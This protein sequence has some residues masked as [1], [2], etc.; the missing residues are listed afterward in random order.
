MIP[1]QQDN[2]G[3]LYGSINSHSIGRKRDLMYRSS[4]LLT[5]L[6]FF[7]TKVSRWIC[8]PLLKRTLCDG[9]DFESLRYPRYC[10]YCLPANTV[11]RKENILKFRI[12]SSPKQCT[13]EVTEWVKKHSLNKLKID[14]SM[15]GQNPWLL[16]ALYIWK[17]YS[18]WFSLSICLTTNS[19]Q[20]QPNQNLAECND[21]H[22]NDF[23]LNVFWISSSPQ[24]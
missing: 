13:L 21:S 3:C 16:E 12:I 1:R 14:W 6:L 24:S 18:Q 10:A 22:S 4:C 7:I 20:E 23:L 15:T 8:H 2:I 9:L 17:V 5:S 11:D 19:D